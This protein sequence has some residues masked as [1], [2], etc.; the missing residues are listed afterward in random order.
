[1]NTAGL[2]SY[3]PTGLSFTTPI[4]TSLSGS[5][6]TGNTANTTDSTAPIISNI[7][8]ND[9]SQNAARIRWNT[10]DPSDSLV[11]YGPPNSTS[12]ATSHSRCD[13]SG[14]VT[15]HCV[16]VTNLLAGT[17][18]MYQVVS[19]NA[20]GLTNYSAPAGS[21]F[22]TLPSTIATS[23]PIS[24]E[25]ATTSGTSLKNTTAPLVTEVHATNIT[26]FAAQ[27]KWQTDQPADS[28][29]TYGSVSLD[30]FS[31]DVRCDGGGN[32]TSHCVMLSDL[33]PGMPFYYRVRSLNANGLAGFTS[34]TFTTLPLSLNSMQVDTNTVT[35]APTR[36]SSLTAAPTPTPAPA[37]PSTSIVA[38][39]T[40]DLQNGLQNNIA[41][42][43]AVLKNESGTTVDLSP[44]TRP[45][46]ETAPQAPAVTSAPQTSSSPPP[47]LTQR[48]DAPDVYDDSDGDGI[49]DYDEIHIYHTEPHN[50]RTAGC[51][52][53]DGERITLGLDPLTCSGARVPVESPV[54]SDATQTNIYEVTSIQVHTVPLIATTTPVKPITTKKIVEASSTP[55]VLPTQQEVFFAGK[56]LPNSFVTLY[57]Y[58]TPIVVTV[59]TDITGAWKYTLD[60]E[61]PDGNH[62]LYVATVD[63]GGK[64]L[65]KSPAVPFV[66]TAEAA[67]F[68]PLIV[69]ET[70]PVDPLDIL[71]SNM[72]IVALAG[73]AIFAILALGILG[74]RHRE[75]KSSDIASV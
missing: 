2:P 63:S 25:A 56:S 69:T 68:T 9:V 59:K 40:A 41:Q 16:Y 36:T 27:I 28:H 11:N 34:G 8:S 23:T 4:D 10:D 51:A 29:V 65:A 35:A 38:S 3:G 1:M 48:F 44:T 19:T 54:T 39:S 42:I 72:L 71:R 75:P 31:S 43:T 26:A 7:S 58:S 49:S 74:L 12:Y 61:L 64:I 73:F 45:I 52:L 67:E 6:S 47:V 17:V 37:V 66:K 30:Q 46:A 5:T 62:N 20:A 13:G 53:T 22:T 50:A 60:S 15:S 21:S 32:V 24:P 55:P 18:Y 14:L 70:T 57:I 33:L